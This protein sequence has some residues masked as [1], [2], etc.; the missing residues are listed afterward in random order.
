MDTG[1]LSSTQD[2]SISSYKQKTR[3]PR[4]NSPL[5][6]PTNENLAPS[7]HKGD[8]LLV[9]PPPQRSLSFSTIPSRQ[10]PLL[11]LPISKPYCSFPSLPPKSSINKKPFINKKPLNQKWPKSSDPPRKTQSSNKVILRGDEEDDVVIYSLAPPP[12]S[13]PL[14]RFPVKPKAG[15]NVEAATRIDA[16]ATS[17]LMKLL[18]LC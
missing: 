7:N 15:C 4:M 6:S 12:S 8:G 9:R 17:N 10:P 3:N 13:L 5:I 18:H 14:P 11:P 16:N 1:V 2:Q